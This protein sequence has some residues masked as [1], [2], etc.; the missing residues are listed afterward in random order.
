MTR[1]VVVGNPENRRVSM[2][3]EAVTQAG[4]A[5]PK[6]L[7][8]VDLLEGRAHLADHLTSETVMRIESPGENFQVEQAFLK[9]GAAEAEAEG[10]PFLSQSA[11]DRLTFDRGLILHP[12]QW[13][14]GFRSVLLGW[15]EE[16]QSHPD[17][18]V[19]NRPAEIAA[20]FDKPACHRRFSAAGIAVP[21]VLDNISCYEELTACMQETGMRRVFVKLA[22]GSSASGVVA[23]Q[24]DGDRQV[25]ITSAEI[26]RGESLKLY[27][28]LKLRRYTRAQDIADLIDA[29][30]AERAHVEERLPKASLDGRTR[31]DLRVV[32]IAGT[33][34]HLV[35]RQGQSPMTNLHLGNQRGDADRLLKQLGEAR[36]RE[37]QETCSD[38]LLQFPGCLYAGVDVLLSPGF[39]RHYALEINAF[40]DLLPGVFWQGR[41]TYRTEVEAVVA[42]LMK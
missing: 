40:G 16:L 18:T 22:H 33:A 36:W 12:R 39:R 11:V 28:S 25:A 2:F 20:M 24:R 35:V 32:A 30:S 15:R 14:L 38:A 34:R 19:M 7:S 5:P 8:Y 3:R 17:V 41:D 23:Y 27:N 13:F 10:S 4:Y 37:I 31:F 21:T 29:L 1:F 42:T 9:A 26:V 6:V